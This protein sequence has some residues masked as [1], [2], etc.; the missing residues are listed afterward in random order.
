M[1]FLSQVDPYRDGLLDRRLGRIESNE[2]S[3]K[4]EKCEKDDMGTGMELRSA[5]KAKNN[6]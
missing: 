1:Y 5:K 3:K 2:K 4:E 6:F